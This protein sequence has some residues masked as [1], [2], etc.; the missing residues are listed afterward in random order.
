MLSMLPGSPL[1]VPRTL[2]VSPSSSVHQKS[3]L[4]LFPLPI[5]AP[6]QHPFLAHPIRRENL[7]TKGRRRLRFPQHPISRQIAASSDA[8]KRQ[9]TTFFS[10][11]YSP[12][13]RAQTAEELPS[14]KKAMVERLRMQQKMPRNATKTHVSPVYSTMNL[15]RFG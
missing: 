8:R 15:C 9:R 10:L 4:R 14:R 7:P 1:S 3:V 12:L 13:P 6:L 5:R 2:A 11:I